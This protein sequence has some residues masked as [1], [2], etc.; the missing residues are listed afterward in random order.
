MPPRQRRTTAPEP[1]AALPIEPIGIVIRDR[2]I[3]HPPVRVWAYLWEEES[4]TVAAADPTPPAAWT[5]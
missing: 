3:T 4:A 2:A 5:G 1:S